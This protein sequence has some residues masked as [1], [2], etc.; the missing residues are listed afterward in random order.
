MEPDFH[1]GVK[2][3]TLDD[4]W[5][6]ATT[7]PCQGC[8]QALLFFFIVVLHNYF[9]SFLRLFSHVGTTVVPAEGG[10]LTPER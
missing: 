3:Y 5:E 7:S 8:L 9:L 2:V 4:S 1:L 10:K 6:W